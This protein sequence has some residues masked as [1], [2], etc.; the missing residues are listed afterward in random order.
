MTPFIGYINEL[1]YQKSFVCIVVFLTY[2][3][4][5]HYFLNLKYQLKIVCS[6]VTY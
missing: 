4:F 2:F 6:A 5:S 1:E 3:V